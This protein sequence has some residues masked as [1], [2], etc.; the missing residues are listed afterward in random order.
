VSLLCPASI[1]II[2]F[3]I[4][5]LDVRLRMERP[6]KRV[7]IRAVVTRRR[8]LSNLARTSECVVASRSCNNLPFPATHCHSTFARDLLGSGSGAVLS[9]PNASRKVTI[10]VQTRIFPKSGLFTGA[11]KCHTETLLSSSHP[12]SFLAMQGNAS[13]QQ[14][15]LHQNPTNLNGI[16]CV[17]QAPTARPTTAQSA[18][19][20]PCSFSIICRRPRNPPSGSI[21]T[22]VSRAA[23]LGKC[24]RGAHSVGALRE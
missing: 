6:R 7:R 20:D 24:S 14:I 21:R 3:L 1:T 23:A 13:C 5:L 11:L 4:F 8:A 10:G 9:F 18:A 16:R 15:P 12:E 19:N 2:G 22:F 17:S